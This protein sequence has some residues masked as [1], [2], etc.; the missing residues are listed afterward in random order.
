M[1]KALLTLLVLAICTL[2][3]PGQQSKSGA[4]SEPQWD[5]LYEALESEDWS[6]ATELSD[7]YLKQ[8][9]QED[10]DKSM[11]R[12]RYMLIF[13]SAGKVSQR[14]MT[15]EE[16]GKILT[17]SVGKEV[18]LPATRFTAKCQAPMGAFCV[19]ESGDLFRA[20][21]NIKGTNIF[22]FERV[23]LKDKLDGQ[24]EGDFGVVQGIV[25]SFEL[26]PNKSTIWIMRLLIEKGQVTFGEPKR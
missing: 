17:D 10:G 9:K 15:H 23:K 4:I 2:A 26:N 1:R 12:L 5:R 6:K 16:L 22:A 18:G 13:A 14:T 11:A 21:T 24:H 25:T 20:A 8:L 7:T 19:E 3:V